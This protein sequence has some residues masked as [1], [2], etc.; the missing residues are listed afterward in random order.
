MTPD[1]NLLPVMNNKRLEKFSSK[2][3]TDT[4]DHVEQRC[5]FLFAGTDL[6]QGSALTL[7]MTVQ[8]PDE[9]KGTKNAAVEI[10]VD[11]L[12]VEQ[13]SDVIVSLTRLVPDFKTLM[14]Y[15][16]LHSK[17][18]GFDLQKRVRMQA[19]LYYLRNQIVKSG[20]TL[21]AV[22]AYRQHLVDLKRK[23]KLGVL[24]GDD[25][26]LSPE[27]VEMEALEKHQL[28]IQKIDKA[29]QGVDL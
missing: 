11:N 27:Q 18:D 29:L 8:R 16:D 2:Y 28:Q 14:R 12:T 23:E 6:N 17:P 4:N 10:K 15:D 1:P 5:F 7:D 3:I 19:P 21:A 13:C 24:D 9:P 20:Y 22:K 25:S 26:T